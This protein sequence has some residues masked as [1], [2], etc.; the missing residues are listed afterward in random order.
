MHT[1]TGNITLYEKEPEDL[2]SVLAFPRKLYNIVNNPSNNHIISWYKGGEEFI[3]HNTNEFAEKILAGDEFTSSN[4]ASFVRQLN[5]YDFHKIKS[6]LKDKMS[7]IFYHKY[8]VKDRPS[9]LKQIKRK[10]ANQIDN[11][12]EPNNGQVQVCSKSYL[13]YIPAEKTKVKD[14]SEQDKAGK[15]KINKH[16]LSNLYSNFLKS[17]HVGRKKQ[18]EIEH[19]IDSIYRQNLE[20]ITQNKTLLNEI[21]NKTEY[22]KTLEQLFVFIL[23]FFMK[24]NDS[25]HNVNRNTD[26]INAEIV[27]KIF[28]NNKDQTLP[29][30][31]S[32]NNLNKTT[33]SHPM[34]SDE[35][36]KLRPSIPS[37][38]NMF[39]YN[40]NNLPS[41]G[42]EQSYNYSPF[43][44]FDN[45]EKIIFSRRDA[46]KQDF[47][48]FLKK[49]NRFRLEKSES[50]GSWTE[51]S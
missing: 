33:T 50:A 32:S 16:M 1:S 5:M 29:N 8:F 23:E 12:E 27:K 19:K 46:M 43:D 20:L 14:D 38:P 41:P 28:M 42:H 9:L 4:Y 40:M 17:L 49:E 18:D 24:K 6:R 31:M 35:H 48:S 37:S 7:D 36:A 2:L 15:K 22:T 51:D 45:N 39:H 10:T 13:P 30:L 21:N 26:F 25:D 47:K 3:I 11:S 44:L 34:L